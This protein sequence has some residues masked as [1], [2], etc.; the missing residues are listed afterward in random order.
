MQQST[1]LA[2]GEA[3][4][5]AESETPTNPAA[6]ALSEY[7]TVAVAS[8]PVPLPSG[9]MVRACLLVCTYND[10][11]TWGIWLGW[12]ICYNRA[13]SRPSSR[14]DLSLPSIPACSS[15]NLP[16][17]PLRLAPQIPAPSI[18]WSYSSDSDE[19]TYAPYTQQQI[20]RYQ[21]LHN[22]QQP[23]S[24]PRAGG[25][26]GLDALPTLPLPDAQLKGA[27]V[28][29]TPN[30]TPGPSSSSSSS[31]A[32][33]AALMSDRAHI[34]SSLVKDPTTLS[35]ALSLL[36]KKAGAEPERKQQRHKRRKKLIQALSNDR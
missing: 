4:A 11:D 21:H 8:P 25:P 17:T 26:T 36:A 15:P 16:C 30:R 22:Q 3:K 20:A 24:P 29:Q 35:K 19:P 9:V 14:A 32:A 6:S 10:T 27:G 23:K 7:T 31:T 33:S 1:G 34:R 28:A 18:V 2:F 12:H 5:A 13:R